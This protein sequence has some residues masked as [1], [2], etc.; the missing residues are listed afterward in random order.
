M[1]FDAFPT[2][3]IAEICEIYEVILLDAYGVLVH[4]H[5]AYP[6][7]ATL[8]DRF[9]NTDKPYYILTNDA[10]S[11]PENAAHKYQRKGLNISPDRVITSGMLLNEY[12]RE[13][14]LAQAPCM[15]LGPRDSIRYVELA[16]GRIISPEQD[17]DEYLAVLVI[18][19]ETGFPFV[20]TVDHVLNHL[21]HAFD[22][23]ESVHL[24][25]PNPDLI[26]PRDERHFGIAAGSLAAI[27]EAILQRRYPHR[28]DM[29]FVSLGKPRTGLFAEAARRG[30]TKNMIM[31]GDQL[32]TDIAG[33]NGFG[34]DS[35]LLTTGVT[36]M[37][38]S[39]IPHHC[40]PT[41]LMK[42][43]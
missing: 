9:N 6:G 36:S 38:W 18:G 28:S 40:R 33:A 22:D 14:Q 3:S 5:G 20:E 42:S 31:I 23:G 41:Y 16:G 13:H 27:Y 21:F 15:V 8:I 34:V 17:L 1:T 7:A 29:H 43:L 32:E 30:G 19:D 4:A 2:I 10:A 11:L 12:F 25:L 24:V 39:S 35:V 26:Y 37:K